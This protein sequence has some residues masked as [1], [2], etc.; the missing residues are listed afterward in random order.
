MLLILF[1]V[2][3][4]LSSFL[5]QGEAIITNGGAL[6]MGDSVA[7]FWLAQILAEKHH[8]PFYYNQFVYSDLLD[9]SNFITPLIGDL[10]NRPWVNIRSE[11]DII[12][13]KEADVILYTDILSRIDFIAPEEFAR[14]KKKFIL[15]AVPPIKDLPKNIITVA[16]HIRKGNGG[17][18]HY[19]GEQS[20][21]QEFEFDRS[22][23]QYLFNYENYAFEWG[24]YQR[25][26][27]H[28]LENKEFC[29]AVV[30][31]VGD[32]ETKFPPNQF[33]ID[34]IIKL[35]NDLL[36]V[37][38]H[39]VICTD[40]KNPEK[41][42]QIIKQK[43]NKPHNIVIEYENDRHLPFRDRVWR[44]LYTLS[45]CDVLIRGQS[46]FSRTAELIGNHKLVM[47]PLKYY[48]DGD[49]LIMHKIVVKGS[50]NSLIK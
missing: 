7:G 21:I 2:C 39:V 9:E 11:D 23:V 17:G 33:Y 48:W 3:G 4:F 43:V 50:I 26:N 38:M 19:D 40:D 36:N 30:D 42:V 45:R 15:K 28:L 8:I 32:W 13:N 29:R 24:D 6:Q 37:P 49:K 5:L 12:R 27:G 16:V 10:N 20:S 44:D 46:Y 14:F 34:Q 35:S 18:L 1:I 47:Y 41:L 22:Q 25:I 31:R